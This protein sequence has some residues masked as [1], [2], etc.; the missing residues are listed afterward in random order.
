MKLLN[1]TWRLNDLLVVTKLLTVFDC[2]DQESEALASFE[3][4]PVASR[5]AS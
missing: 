3:Q 4:R 5:G 1:V 2:F